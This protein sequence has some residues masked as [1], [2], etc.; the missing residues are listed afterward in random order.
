MSIPAIPVVSRLSFLWAE[1][2]AVLVDGYAVVLATS[3]ATTPL[4]IATASAL[5]LEPGTSITHAAIKTCA[6]SECLVLWV[7]EAGVRCYAAGNPGR[8]ADAL[9]RQ[10]AA[11]LDPAS[12]LAA[13]REIFWRMFGERAPHGRS[14]EQLR[15]MEGARVRA[16]YAAIAKREGVSWLGRNAKDADDPV[17]Q[18]IS[19][20]N[21]A[22]YGLVEAV[23]LTLGFSP[24]IGFVHSG[25]DRSFVYDIADCVKFSTVTP[26]AMRIAKESADHLEGRTRRA[27][28]DLFRSMRLAEQIV[29]A[30]EGVLHG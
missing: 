10:A 2:G 8:N 18:A 11:V 23:V 6:D 3:D 30:I 12:R 4:P 28:R 24:A 1:R 14:V 25:G 16:L 26:L 5:L 29:S 20:A 15:G 9:L 19:I 22:L 7:G 13:A 27:C 17:N 21:A